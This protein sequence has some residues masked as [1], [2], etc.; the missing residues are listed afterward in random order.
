MRSQPVKGALIL[1][2]SF[3]LAG[4]LYLLTPPFNITVGVLLSGAIVGVAF[5]G[6]KGVLAGVLAGLLGFLIAYLASGAG[7][8]GFNVMGELLGFPGILVP[9]IYYPLA[10]GLTSF[11]AGLVFQRVWGRGG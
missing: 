6:S 9:L 10:V 4:S 11:L 3:V 5:R 1:L 7:V 8:L 2:S